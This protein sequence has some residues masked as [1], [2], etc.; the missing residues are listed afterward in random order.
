MLSCQYIGIHIVERMR[1]EI[2][3]KYIFCLP[4]DNTLIWTKLYVVCLQ[5]SLQYFGVDGFL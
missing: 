4:R 2:D 3:V 1:P 5:H